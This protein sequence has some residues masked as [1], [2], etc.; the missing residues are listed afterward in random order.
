MS[1]TWKGAIVKES[2]EDKTLLKLVRIIKEV[3][4]KYYI[5]VEDSKKE[6]FV[7]KTIKSIKERYYVYLVKDKVMYVIFKNHMFKFSRGYPELDTARD[8]GKSIGILEEQ[9]SFE[10]L[11]ESPWG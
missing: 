7:Q 3:Q 8:Y 9:M 10:K 5:E 4:Y 6:E 11:I 2:L 1:M